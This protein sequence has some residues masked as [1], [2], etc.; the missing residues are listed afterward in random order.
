M[1]HRTE[2]QISI[3]V[4]LS[5]HLKIPFKYHVDDKLKENFPKET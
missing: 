5:K 3:S 4:T 2:G 1:F